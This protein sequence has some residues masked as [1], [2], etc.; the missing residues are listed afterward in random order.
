[1]V[2]Y[3][4]KCGSLRGRLW[5][6]GKVLNVG[7]SSPNMHKGTHEEPCVTSVPFHTS[8]KDKALQPYI[9]GQSR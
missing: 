4:A 2:N 9:S 6:G 3:S 7:F 1:M 8:D 5:R